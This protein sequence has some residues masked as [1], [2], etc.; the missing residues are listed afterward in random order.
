MAYKL[1]RYNGTFLVNVDDGSVESSSSDLRFVGKNYAGYGEL[2]NE[3][4]LHL[5][6]NF[7]NNT[8]PPRAISGQLWYDSGSR[9]IKYYNGSRFKTVGGAETGVTAPTGLEPGEFWFDTSARQLYTWTGLDYVLIGPE[10]GPELGA[11]GVTSQVVKDDNGNNYTVL[12]LI[13]G[14]KTI[15]VIS[16]DEFVLDESQTPVEDFFLPEGIRRI[17]KGFNLTKTNSAGSSSNDFV[18]WGTASNSQRLGGIA[19]DQFL[20]KGQIV[21]PNRVDFSDNGFRLDNDLLIRIENNTEPIIES[22]QGNDITFRITVA[23]TDRREVLKITQN[24]IEPRD[25]LTYD[26]GR[27]GARWKEVYAGTYIGNLT[28]NVTGNTSGGFHRGDVRA[29][30]DTTL[31][32]AVTKTIGYE[33]ARLEGTLFG[34]ITGTAATTG[35]SS[36]LAGISPSVD[37]PGETNKTSIPVR[38][39]GGAIKATRFEGPSDQSDRLLITDLNAGTYGDATV[40]AQP[41]TIVAR[42]TSGN[43]SAILF[44][45]TATAAYYADLSEKYLADKE[46]SPGTVVSIGGPAEITESMSGD[47]A[48]GVISTNPAFMMNKDLPN[49]VYVALKGRVPTKI[50]GPVKKGDRLVAA[51]DGTASKANPDQYVNVFAICLTDIEDQSVVLAESLIL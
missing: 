19:A 15:G 51:N 8:A 24:G 30:D 6:E 32:N 3:N 49:G 35:D 5:L 17:K 14:G 1:D 13:A 2:Q 18:F 44:Q 50:C 34:N 25:S 46:Y 26:L 10:A 28:G 22:L 39:T 45:G 23:P 43:V 33:G 48:I 16:N 37:I 21:F 38:T 11:A 47:R 31:I 7:A 27:P 42:D 20:Q 29:I 4:F 36:R 41:T 12:R 9:R 40:A